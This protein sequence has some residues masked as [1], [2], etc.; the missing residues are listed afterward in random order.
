VAYVPWFIDAN[1]LVLFRGIEDSP[2][3]VQDKTDKYGIVPE[4]VRYLEPIM[5]P[6]RFR[7]VGSHMDQ[8][9]FGKIKRD[10]PMF[11]IIFKA[12]DTIIEKVREFY[13]QD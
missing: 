3:V 13:E 6:F 11:D 4:D 8:A 10:S 1:V 12:D 9:H 7:K 5:V 2:F